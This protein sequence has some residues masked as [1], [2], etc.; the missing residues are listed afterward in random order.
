M[1]MKDYSGIWVYAEQRDGK[2]D[3]VVPELLT[4]AREL[5]AYT[6]EELTAVL[7]GFQVQELAAELIACGADRVILAESENLAVYSVRPYQQAIAQLAEK[8]RPSIILYGATCQGRELA[9]RVMV[10]LDTG[11]T[12]DAM[13]LGFDEDG[14]F[15]QTTPAYGGSIYA[16]IVIPRRRPQMATVRPGMFCP[17]QPDYSR[18]GETICERLEVR[19]DEDFALVSEAP[20]STGTV[21]LDKA[22]VIVAGGR[23]VKTGK[24]LDMLRELAELLDGRVAGSRPLVD[25]GLLPHACQIGQSGATVK[26]EL[27]INVAVSGSVQ[28]QVGMKGAKRIISINLNKNAPI[29]DISQYGA[30]ANFREVLPALIDEIK[31]RRAR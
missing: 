14:V 5:A 7:P 3:G 27:L 19:E 12:A 24:E 20:K 6:R 25:S 8:Y 26:P 30:V 9:P 21:P 31:R 10:S 28:Y 11:L 18:R 15:Y 23:G 16:D 22:A 1:A 17:A 13:D 4:K 2:L 29:F